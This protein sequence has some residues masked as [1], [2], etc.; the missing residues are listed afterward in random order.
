MQG[1][2]TRTR[3]GDPNDLSEFV[4]IKEMLPA[5]AGVILNSPSIFSPDHHV[6]RTRGGDPKEGDWRHDTN[7]MLPAHAG[8]IPRLDRVKLE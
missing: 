6:T 3:G 8:V 2:V 7:K 5:H 4:R 1:D